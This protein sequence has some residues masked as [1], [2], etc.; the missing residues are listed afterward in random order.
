MLIHSVYKHLLMTLLCQFQAGL[1]QESLGLRDS[2][3][4]ISPVLWGLGWVEGRVGTERAQEGS[5]EG[6]LEEGMWEFG[7]E[8]C[9]GDH[10]AKQTEPLI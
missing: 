4:Q 5:S 6:F 7:F 10:K 9:I 3:L 8:K 2:W 1:W